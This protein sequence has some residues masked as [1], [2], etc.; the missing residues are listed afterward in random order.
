MESASIPVYAFSCIPSSHFLCKTPCISVVFL[1][2]I[3]DSVL[4]HY[5][6]TYIFWYMF[7]DPLNNQTRKVL[8][9]FQKQGN[10]DW[11]LNL[12]SF[13]HKCKNKSLDY[14]IHFSF[15]F[16]SCISTVFCLMKC[17]VGMTYYQK[18]MTVR[19]H[20]LLSSHLQNYPYFSITTRLEHPLVVA[21]P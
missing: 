3:D 11:V 2:T 19:N 20:F 16:T 15:Y 10:K 1:L 4:I 8:S 9:P 21:F 17:M 5:F 13:T 6:Y 7:L 12:D 18:K 14:Y